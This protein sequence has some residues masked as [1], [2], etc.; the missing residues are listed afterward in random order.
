MPY[1]PEQLT[2]AL[3]QIDSTIHKLRQTLLTLEA[4]PEP[5]R[6]RSQI[7]LARRRIEAFT[8]ASELLR[9]ERDNAQ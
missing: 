4:K 8:I 6:Y 3:R 7:T 1:T 9:R 2:E 5:P